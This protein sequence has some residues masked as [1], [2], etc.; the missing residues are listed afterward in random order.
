M[1]RLL[2]FLVLAASGIAAL[3]LGAGGFF[4]AG[5]G[6]ER[7]DVGPDTPSAPG[8]AP[9]DGVIDLNQV[10][11][12]EDVTASVNPTGRVRMQG[13]AVPRVWEDPVTR[14]T[15]EFPT[16]V[17]W[18]FEAERMRGVVDPVTGDQAVACWKVRVRLY[19]EPS[20]L[21]RAEAE[22]LH[23]DREGHPG[24]VHMEIT[25]EEARADFMKMSVNGTERLPGVRT[26]V[27]MT[28]GVVLED[29]SQHLVIRTDEAVIELDKRSAEGQSRL[30]AQS[31]DWSLSGTGFRL[32]ERPYRLEILRDTDFDIRRMSGTAAPAAPGPFDLGGGP[33]HPTRITAKGSAVVTRSAGAEA[34]TE[35]TLTE[36]VRV[37]QDGGIDL[38][39]D[40]VALD[41]ARRAPRSAAAPSVAV[42]AGDTAPSMRLKRLVAAGHV[43][44]ESQPQPDGRRATSLTAP[45]MTCEFPEKGLGTTT[46]SGRTSLT[47]TGDLPSPGG[48]TAP[49]TMTATCEDA[50]VYGP[51]P[52]GMPE[53][54]AMLLL[55]G[56]AHVTSLGAGDARPQTI[57]GNVIRLYLK[58][59]APRDPSTPAATATHRSPTAV[60]FDAT[61]NVRLDGPRV[62]ARADVLRG[63]HLDRP[64]FSIVAEGKD[65]YVE[66]IEDSTPR[67]GKTPAAAGDGAPH[68][69]RRDWVPE[70]LLAERGVRARIAGAGD[71][72]VLSGSSLTYARA[73][74]G[75]LVGDAAERAKVVLDAAGERDGSV[76]APRIAFDLDGAVRTLTTEGA[77]D[78]EFWL[79]DH[80][81]K[82]SHAATSKALRGV[83][84]VALSSGTRIELTGLLGA[85]A[86]QGLSISLRD[87]A[88]IERFEGDRTTDRI[89][90]ARVEATLYERVVSATAPSLFASTSPSRPAGT[91]SEP[92]PPPEA[93]PA[94]TASRWTLRAS[95]RLAL[96]F[97]TES[98]GRGAGGLTSLDAVGQVEAFDASTRLLG[99][100]LVFDGAKQEGRLTGVAGR[101]TRVVRGT[102]DLA[103]RVSSP[104]VRFAVVAGTFGSAHFAPPFAAL[105]PHADAKT[106]QRERFTLASKVGALV[107]ERARAS[108]DA[109]DGDV[110]LTSDPVDAAGETSVGRSLRM[111][112]SKITLLGA[113]QGD[114]K[115]EAFDRLIAEGE[116][117]L[118]EVLESGKEPVRAQGD[119]VEYDRV[120]SLVTISGANGRRV[121]L[122]SPEMEGDFRELK[123]DPATGLWD[124]PGAFVRLEGPKK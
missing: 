67:S 56:S 58:E 30:V 70:S 118:L 96:A 66:L 45:E 15:L 83:S 74:G 91:A 84:R 34:A 87:G 75:L 77:T 119:R 106:K 40:R 121:Y 82:S 29:F 23:A 27:H 7:P 9:K 48:R 113:T 112:T 28:K 25:G 71:P 8:T 13:P 31:P 37:H 97:G 6:T 60:A 20:T 49:G 19:R 116:E 98:V 94:A 105:L 14:Q 36:D 33:F 102:G 57:D 22:A 21:T 107:I 69:E 63:A 76:T 89:V 103:Q 92:A 61:G 52:E 51:P 109:G 115:A 95:E 17:P 117:T 54:S 35:V 85:D 5:S 2:L 55:A 79:G 93:S 43:A 18:E 104:E 101:T 78:A 64:T 73:K 16:F 122:A 32:R 26:F 1:K 62:V 24:R 68:K 86:A 38:A 3:A 10:P 53:V 90:A 108:V 44:I 72:V 110:I 114:A 4:G 124:W 47:F 80:A 59:P 123:F 120:A 46:F 42:P 88:K 11:S 65:P 39:A 41:L 50:L 12:K 111:T 81:K 99:D 100:R